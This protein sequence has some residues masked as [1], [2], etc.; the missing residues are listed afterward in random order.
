MTRNII[1]SPL[2]DTEAQQQIEAFKYLNT[3]YQLYCNVL[4]NQGFDTD[5]DSNSLIHSLAMGIVHGEH[6]NWLAQH[7][8]S[9]K[10]DHF[11]FNVQAGQVPG[12][13]VDQILKP[14]TA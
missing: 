5:P 2:S 7:L 8:Q 10:K 4:K 6:M 11:R 13:T 12:V 1:T 3:G 14:V 9:G